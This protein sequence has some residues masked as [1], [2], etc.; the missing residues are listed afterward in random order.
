MNLY[1]FEIHSKNEFHVL[2]DLITIYS[3]Y[4]TMTGKSAKMLRAKLVT[5]LSIYIKYGYNKESK[6]KACDLLGLKKTNLNCL[7]SELREGGFLIKSDRNTRDSYLNDELHQ[8]S[9]YYQ[10]KDDA[11]LPEGLKVNGE[12]PLLLMISLAADG[13]KKA[14]I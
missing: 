8:L 10:I 12:N 2:E 6:Q 7:N 11:V 13:G 9:E 4:R 1:K 14:H 3:C 5:L